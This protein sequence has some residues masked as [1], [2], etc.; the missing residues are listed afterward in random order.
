LQPTRFLVTLTDVSSKAQSA[1]KELIAYVAACPVETLRGLLLADC[2]VLAR[3][4]E[5]GDLSSEISDYLH[6]KFG[7]AE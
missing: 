7:E 2:L 6:R 4:I 3:H 5:A 1:L